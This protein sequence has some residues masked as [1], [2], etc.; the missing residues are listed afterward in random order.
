MNKD[1]LINYIK[2]NDPFYRFAIMKGYSL[3]QLLVVKKRIDAEKKTAENSGSSE[4]PSPS[5]PK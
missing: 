2:E 4:E 1:A 3:E 5:S